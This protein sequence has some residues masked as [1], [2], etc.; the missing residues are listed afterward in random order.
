[1][2]MHSEKIDL[3]ATALSTAQSALH[4]ASKDSKNPF[5]NSTYAD[6]T[7]VW[8]A[9]REALSSNGL[10]VIQCTQPIEGKLFL[11]TTLAHSSGQWVK[12]YFPLTV[13]SKREKPSPGKRENLLQEMGSALTYTRRYALAAIVGVAPANEDDDGN[14]GGKSYKP[15]IAKTVHKRIT[16]SEEQEDQIEKMLMDAPE[17]RKEIL[18]KMGIGSFMELTVNQ[19]NGVINRIRSLLEGE[20]NA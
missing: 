13:E 9:C 8:N 17:L 7:A 14:E 1:M 4:Q 6:L 10:C 5:F 16:I 19:Y 12:S 15:Q 20:N 2:E 11:I 3:L 18:T